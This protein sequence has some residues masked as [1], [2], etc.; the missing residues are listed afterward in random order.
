MGQIDKYLL[1]SSKFFLNSLFKQQIKCFKLIRDI[2]SMICG[3]SVEMWALWCFQ[4]FLLGPLF[5]TECVCVC[6][7]PGSRMFTKSKKQTQ[8]GH[9]YRRTG[10]QPRR[11]TRC[12]LYISQTDCDC[13]RPAWYTKETHTNYHN[14]AII[15][16]ERHLQHTDQ[17]LSSDLDLKKQ[18]FITP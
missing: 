16:T 1:F 8:S 17:F 13:F 9:S 18:V 10:G 4:G 7:Y 12:N 11:C 6:V 5:P 14:C 15:S 3:K 2:L